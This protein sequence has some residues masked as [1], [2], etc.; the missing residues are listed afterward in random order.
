MHKLDKGK[1]RTRREMILNAKI[2][3][4]EMDQVILDLGSDVNVLSK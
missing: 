4:F 3:E 2:R 1:K